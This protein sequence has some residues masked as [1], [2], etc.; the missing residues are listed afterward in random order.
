M[1]VDPKDFVIKVYTTKVAANAGLESAALDV[2]TIASGK[3]AGYQDD[4]YFLQF[5]KYYYRFD[6]NE[7]SMGI[8]IDWTLVVLIGILVCLLYISLGIYDNSAASTF[9]QRNW[10]SLFEETEAIK[11]TIKD[12]IYGVKS[13][14]RELKD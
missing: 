9:N 11:A 1:V 10:N 14:M 12:E 5:T 8:E 3:I 4:Q 13:V 6:F 2:D 7:P